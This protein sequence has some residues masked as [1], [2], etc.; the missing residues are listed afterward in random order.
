MTC[1]SVLVSR[2]HDGCSSQQ[3]QWGCGIHTADPGN[4]L[5]ASYASLENEL[6]FS[7]SVLA[8]CGPWIMMSQK[9]TVLLTPKS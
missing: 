5:G 6:H 9:K 7:Q 8:K 1:L 2:M 3:Q 4:W